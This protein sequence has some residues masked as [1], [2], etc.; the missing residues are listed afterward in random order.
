MIEYS[1]ASLQMSGGDDTQ[2]GEEV[3]R[4]LGDFLVVMIDSTRVIAGILN[5]NGSASARQA[6]K[7]L[8]NHL[9]EIRGR[10][11]ATEDA[12]ARITPVASTSIAQ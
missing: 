6:E 2:R 11:Q 3:V 9:L 1:F 8:R 7:D 4:I 12:L 5:P 10:D